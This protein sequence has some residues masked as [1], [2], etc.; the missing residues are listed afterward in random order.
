MEDAKKAEGGDFFHNPTK[1]V[2]VGPATT[3][4]VIDL[5]KG[6]GGGD[7]AL[8]GSDDGS[9]DRL[10]LS[11]LTFLKIVSA[12]HRIRGDGTTVSIAASFCLPLR[13]APPAKTAGCE[14]QK[15]VLGEHG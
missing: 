8:T 10:K 12:R 11:V 13:R 3:P 15:Y 9:S 7:A 2:S 14:I 1:A 4:G 6:G 5:E